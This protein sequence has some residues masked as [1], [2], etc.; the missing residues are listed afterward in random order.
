MA[1]IGPK[2]IVCPIGESGRIRGHTAVRGRPLVDLPKEVF[3]GEFRPVL[4]QVFGAKN[5]QRRLWIFSQ[6]IVLE[7][8]PVVLVIVPLV[9]GKLS[10]AQHRR[11]CPFGTRHVDRIF[12]LNL[13]RSIVRIVVCGRKRP[14]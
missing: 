4:G 3:L 10:S 12:V 13:V 7:G 8:G 2:P 14:L 1:Q 6:E 9:I 5:Q 11:P